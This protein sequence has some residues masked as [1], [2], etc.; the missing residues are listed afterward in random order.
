[1]HTSSML[2]LRCIKKD[3]YIKILKKEPMEGYKISNFK[4][5]PGFKIH[6]KD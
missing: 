3:R 4:Y 2:W 1:M 6:I 5:N